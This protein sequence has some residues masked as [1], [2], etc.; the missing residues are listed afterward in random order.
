MDD[1][2]IIGFYWER[3]EK[4]IEE[5]SNKYGN[6]CYSIAYNIL[7][8]HEDAAESVNDTYLDA[9]NSIPPHRPANLST[10]L[11][12][13]TRRI[14]IDKWRKRSAA[15]RGGDE[16]TLILDELSDC[17]PAPQSVEHEVEAAEL[18]QIINKFI[19]SLPCMDRRV[20][21]CRYWYCDSILAIAQQFGFSQGK[22]KMI[23]HRQRKKLLNHLEREGLL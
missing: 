19:L 4:A 22:V 7:A 1:A 11:G 6:Y 15:K 9:W 17:V 20:F 13:I 8:N 12:K 3:S 5:T 14:S 2:Y 10:F 16:I 18:A 23:L 21:I